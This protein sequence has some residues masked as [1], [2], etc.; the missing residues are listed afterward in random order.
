M[1]LTL[2]S[3]WATVRYVLEG[4]VFALI[5]LQ[6]WA[7]VTAPTCASASS[8]WCRC[9]LAT[10]ILIRPA[11]IFPM[12]ALLA[13]SGGRDCRRQSLVAVSW[14]GMRGVVSLA[15]ADPA[16]GHALPPA[17]AHLHDRRD[18]RHPGGAGPDAAGRD[19]GAALPGDPLGRDRRED[20][21]MARPTRRS[22]T[23]SSGHPSR[24]SRPR[25][26][27]MRAGSGARLAWPDEATADG[28]PVGAR[29]T[30]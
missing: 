7:I 24:A 20:A 15:A 25:A 16:A 4:A 1:R 29:I 10:V 14:A 28:E 23:G 17:P 26:E 22:P 21:A 12:Y 9:V 5:G 27:R 18:R 3:T 6:L 2:R 13:R 8:S 30:G 19:P 11:W